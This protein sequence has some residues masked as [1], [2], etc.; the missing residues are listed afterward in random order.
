MGDTKII[1]G[2]AAAVIIGFSAIVYAIFGNEP[3]GTRVTIG[4]LGIIFGWLGLR[5]SKG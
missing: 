4:L 1:S 3:M 5:F 2:T